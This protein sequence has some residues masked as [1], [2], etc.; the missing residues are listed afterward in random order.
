L[1]HQRDYNVKDSPCSEL[2]SDVQKA[3]TAEDLAIRP[4]YG[5]LDRTTLILLSVQPLSAYRFV[6]TFL[7]FDFSGYSDNSGDT[8]EGSR[9]KERFGKGE[10]SPR[11]E[12][13][14]RA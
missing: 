10:E 11:M 7:V 4:W 9:G 13:R 6:V 1:V 8:E 3:R 12:L 14:S 5:V 2:A